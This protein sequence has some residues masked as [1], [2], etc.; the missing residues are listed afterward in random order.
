MAGVRYPLENRRALTTRGLF[1]IVNNSPRAQALVRRTRKSH[2]ACGKSEVRVQC[3]IFPGGRLP[4][5][6]WKG[7]TATRG[8]Q[9]RPTKKSICAEIENQS[10]GDFSYYRDLP[11][12]QIIEFGVEGEGYQT[13]VG[14]RKAWPGCLLLRA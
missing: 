6:N 8:A 9:V 11:F 10:F 12:L 13:L 2:I 7:P 3:Q 4:G 5:C 1:R 14:G